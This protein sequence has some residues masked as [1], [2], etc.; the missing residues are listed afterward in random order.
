M[1][2]SVFDI[3]VIGS[4]ESGTGTALLAASLG[5]SVF[6]TDF[7]SIPDK[8]KAELDAIGIAYEEGTH[9]T[10]LIL[11]AKTVVKKPGSTGKVTYHQAAKRSK[12]QNHRR[13]RVCLPAYA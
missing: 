4:G 7:G 10:E 9:S 12:E 8:Y 5:L 2:N 3:V 6:V 1:A 11:Q 13:N